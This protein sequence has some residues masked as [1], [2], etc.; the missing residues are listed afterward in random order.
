MREVMEYHIHDKAQIGDLVYRYLLCSLTG[1]YLITG[2]DVESQQWVLYESETG[3]FVPAPLSS[4][5]V[6]QQRWIDD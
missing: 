2:F 4:L 3:H 5:R 1:P 6:P